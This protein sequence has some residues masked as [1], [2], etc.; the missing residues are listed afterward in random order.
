MCITTFAAGACITTLAGGMRLTHL[1]GGPCIALFA[2]GFFAATTTV[3]DVRSAGFCTVFTVTVAVPVL[4]ARSAGCAAGFAAFCGAAAPAL[5]AIAAA[6]M[7]R[8][9]TEARR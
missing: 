4:P 7:V 6:I 9:G 5:V 3:V 2:A 1:V 8:N